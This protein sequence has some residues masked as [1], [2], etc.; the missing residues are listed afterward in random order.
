MVRQWHVRF[1]ARSGRSSALERIYQSSVL[2]LICTEVQ[3][4]LTRSET[5]LRIGSWYCTPGRRRPFEGTGSLG[6]SH[7]Y[8]CPNPELVLAFRVATSQR[9]CAAA[10]A[11]DHSKSARRLGSAL[12]ELSHG[13]GLE[14][15]PRGSGVRSQQN[16][17][18]PSRHAR[19]GALRAVPREAGFHGRGKE[20]PGLS[21][22]R[23][24]EKNGHEL[25][26]VPHRS[27]LE[28]C[29]AA[30]E[31]APQ[32]LPAAG[33]SRGSAVRR[34][35]QGSGSR[36]VPGFVNGMHFV[37]PARFSEGQKSGS[38]GRSIPANLRGLPLV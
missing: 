22:R 35:P 8:V 36:P 14:T 2:T 5:K 29:R 25:R 16:Q 15:H 6:G 20:L 13:H 11:A 34:L 17:V 38:R 26:G 12:R 37:P 10:S 3:L 33:S 28:Y 18:S 19:K 24:P 23:A 7:A 4:I 27:R 31:R 1:H 32:P 21:Y 9:P 30:G